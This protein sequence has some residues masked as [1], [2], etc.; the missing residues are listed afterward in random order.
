MGRA[1]VA[2]HYWARVG[3]GEL[4]VAAAAYSFE[5]MGKEPVLVSP[6]YFDPSKYKE[7]FGIDLTR[8]RAE[9][10]KIKLNMFGLYSR[11]ITWYP[12]KKAI[13]K[14]KPE[15]VFIDNANYGPI[16]DSK[17]SFKLIEY[18]HFPFEAYP[19]FEDPSIKVRYSKFPLNV[20]W[21]S[22]IKL[23]KLVIRKNPFESA[24][25]V[26][27]NSA[28]TAKVVESIYNRSPTVLNPPLSPNVE[29]VKNPR[30]FEE[31]KNQVV[32]VG[33]FSEEKRYHWVIESLMP[34]LL[35]ELPEV[36]LKIIGGVGAKTSQAYFEG[37]MKLIEKL[38]LKEKVQL[39][40]NA[41]RSVINEE[42]DSSKVFLHAMINEHWGISVTEAMAR[43]LPVVAHKS[44]GTWSDILQEGKYG[45]GYQD[46]DEAVE[47]IASLMSDSREWKK[48]SVPER[49][50]EFS[51]ENF[52][53]KLSGLVSRIS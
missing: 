1:I 37:L 2:H 30:P 17:R 16:L 5:K 51:L 28:W 4:V 24:D 18:I 50:E 36:K 35:K 43:G 22:Y 49:V 33:R 6:F 31:R 8:Y 15:V 32:M 42:Q 48:H 12:V 27:S 38:N 20:Y 47:A 11:L 23:M 39:L 25:L 41:P 10:G 44:G 7:W 29:V 46:E 21:W 3:G 34:K 19:S 52:Y 45:K 9:I 53:N 14:H 26:L 13:K 40:P